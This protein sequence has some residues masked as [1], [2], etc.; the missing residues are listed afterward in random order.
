MVGPLPLVML[1]HAPRFD[2][3]AAA[4]LARD[5]YGVS[6]SVRALTSERDQNFLL[7]TSDGERLVLKV[8]NALEDPAMLDAQQRA[9]T[10][11]GAT[12]DLAPRVIPTRQGQMLASVAGDGRQHLVWAVSHRPGIPLGLV[13]RRTSALLEHLGA[14]IGSLTQAFRGFD[15][16]ALHRDFYWD[17]ARGRAIVAEYRSMIEDPEV[18]SGVDTLMERFDRYAA[19]LL[20]WLPCSAIHGDL[21]DFNV[22]VEGDRVS[23][24]VDF[25][26]MVYGYTVGDLAI[27]AAYA[28]LDSDD[29]I[30]VTAHLA[31]GYRERHPLKEV[32]IAALFP[33]AALRLATSACVAAN[34]QRQRPDNAYLGVSQAAITRTL[35]KLARIPFGLATAVIRSVCDLPPAPRSDA[36]VAWL[37]TQSFAPILD[38]SSHAVLDLSVG[39]PLIG[40]D[41]DARV[42]AALHSAGA[43]VGI[44]RW[45]EPRLIYTAPFFAGR[46]I[47]LGLDLFAPAG[48]P[49]HAP[50]RGVVHAKAD[51]A[52]TQDYGPVII[53]EHRTG[54]GFTFYTLYGHLSRESLGAL[55]PGQ[56]VEAGAR[57]GTLGTKDENG[58]WPPHLH[59]QIIVD[60]LDM[61]TDFPG[62]GA[63]DQ[64]AVW[65]SLSPDPSGLAGLPASAGEPSKAETLEARRRLVGRNLSIAYADPLKIVRGSRQFLYDDEGRRYLDAYNNVPHVG[66]AH[67][68]VVEAASAQ[69]AVLNT[70]TRYLSDRLTEYAGR[71]VATLP[72]PLGVCYVLNSASEANELALRLARARTGRRDMI[73]LDA[74]YHGN[75]TSLIDLSPYKH[76][77]PGG[78]G[79]PDWVHVAPLPDDFR[80]LYRRDDAECGRKYARHVAELAQR[81]SVAGFLAETCPSVGGQ[82]MLPPG[83]LAEAYRAVRQAGGVCIADEVQTGLGRLGTHCWA[84]E[85][86][87]VVPDIVVMGK[88]LGNGHPLA[89]VVTTREIADAFDNGMEFFS[90]CGGNTVSCAVGL[91]VL[92]VMRDEHLQEH[93]LRVGER[94]LRG[95]RPF[96]D[97]YAVVGDVRGSGLFLG[98]ELVRDRETLEPATTEATAIINKMREDG[99]LL[100]TDGP[101]HNVI[102]I[103][104]PMPFTVEDADRLVETL[105]RILADGL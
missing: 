25:G 30:A 80:G 19:P 52:V 46:T 105:D 9:M 21:N 62:V 96:V 74:A 71:L 101:Y 64:R 68:R 38:V 6:G 28:M 50:L 23:G 53:L 39:S 41:L 63:P 98:V 40:S 57:L 72:A 48:T 92:D 7:E 100:G 83:Y 14:E 1:T 5:L 89:A 35:P 36:I 13:R 67:P 15:H 44:G 87:G 81:R 4:R 90:T 18:G 77:G 104:P 54:D 94:L 55:T 11:V 17:L 22:L 56:R 85:Q 31:R 78:T 58:Q 34:Q 97:R 49:V 26:D 93:A 79:T 99:I 102:K 12:V 20:S 51:N 42:A 84:F 86:H 2:A 60:L 103:R 73:V 69:M 24:V 70:N 32:E 16:A 45:D 91:A 75:T 47:H 27:A 82:L 3:A 66:H 29:P 76:R 37:A 95:L 43:R 10:H 65:R 61:G 88:P 33:L 8:A 59:L